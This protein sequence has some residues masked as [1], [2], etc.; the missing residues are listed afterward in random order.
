M[1]KD[2][3]REKHKEVSILYYFYKALTSLLENFKIDHPYNDKDVETLAIRF[4]AMGLIFVCLKDEILAAI[5]S[6]SVSKSRLFNSE[7]LENFTRHFNQTLDVL[8][9]YAQLCP[10][11]D[12]TD[13]LFGPFMYIMAR[14]CKMCRDQAQFLEF[15]T[16]YGM[17]KHF[18]LILSRKHQL[19]EF[20]NDLI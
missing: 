20:M 10:N 12:K 19:Q 1:K 8:R 13:S 2:L 15:E 17:L 3:K 6:S 14:F 7:S 18:L 16:Q 4:L 9:A 5:N 11:F